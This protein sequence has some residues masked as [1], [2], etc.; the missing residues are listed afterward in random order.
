M[1]NAS[2]ALIIA[3]GVLLAM[4]ILSLLVY[5]GMSMTDMAQS[6]DRVTL[7]QQIADFNKSYL[8]YDKKRMY[9]TEVITVVNKAINHNKNVEATTVDPYYIN[10]KINPKQTF[11]TTVIEIDNTKE[12]FPSKELKGNQITST[13]KGLLGNPNNSYLEANAQGNLGTWQN[14]GKEFIMNNNFV[15]FFAGDTIDKT[16]TTSDQKTTYKMYSALTNFKTAI[17]E[18]EDVGYNDE[19]RVN[20]M[21]FTQI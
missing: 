16:V 8:A 9:G 14:N 1:E 11:E 18:C 2:K 17:F 13:I 21:T 4:M 19:G 7:A 15:D 10:I 6:Q 5:V 12:Y 20:S 3:G